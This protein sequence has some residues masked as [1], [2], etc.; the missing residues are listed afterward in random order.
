MQTQITQLTQITQETQQI[1]KQI[2]VLI[3][4]HNLRLLTFIPTSLLLNKV[5]DL[6]S[7]LSFLN[8]SFDSL[9][10]RFLVP[11]SQVV[12]L[13]A[14][15]SSS[16]DQLKTTKLVIKYLALF[17]Q[18]DSNNLLHSASTINLLSSINLPK[19]I[20]VID[21]LQSQ[22]D[23]IT[24][25]T[26]N[27][28]LVLLNSDM[29]L[30]LSILFNLNSLHTH[31]ISIIDGSL[32]NL[33]T[34]LGK[35]LS[36][37]SFWPE[38]ES[39]VDDIFDKSIYIFKLDYAIKSRKD[40]NDLITKSAKDGI[41]TYFYTCLALTIEKE[42]KDS[43]KSS[44]TLANL[45]SS[46]YPRLLRLFRDLFSRITL[47][48][49]SQTAHT[50]L[51]SS[52]SIF[53]H[54]HISK[55][56][57]KL[58]EPINSAFSERNSKGPIKEDIDKILRIISS[59]LDQVRFDQNLL[60]II[61]KNV[62]KALTTFSAKVENAIVIDLGIFCVGIN[63]NL[64]TNIDLANNLDRISIGIWKIINEYPN[65]SDLLYKNLT[66]LNELTSSLIQPIF[67]QIIKEFESTI[68]KIH[69][70]DFAKQKLNSPGKINENQTSSC[71]IE[72]S[73]RKIPWVI[74]EIL[75][76]LGSSDVKQWTLLLANR[77]I[78][79]YLRHVSIIFPL[80]D[81]G[82]LKIA[83]DL[84]CLFNLDAIGIKF[85]AITCFSIDKIRSRRIVIE[86]IQ[87]IEVF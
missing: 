54:S 76:K 86:N 58:L 62:D 48:D 52:L 24:T 74:Q 31:I 81:Y 11:Y 85:I 73:R 56:L 6:K 65:D 12:A 5:S 67:N 41:V 27:K 69:K 36:L 2:Q 55:S 61:N 75:L 4:K 87:A 77:I 80:N 14:D 47:H 78:I 66:V 30:G 19:G 28:A 46:N 39:F 26:T 68:I 44:K 37:S 32:S 3:Q 25:T 70:E 50:I 84:V 57:S 49:P 53:E 13:Q 64:I 59:E 7:S 29:P 18:L 9:K 43:A 72:F 20:H 83:S 35:A 60:K 40:F 38:M 51:L 34:A 33:L 1:Q 8:S 10:S 45:L 42:L 82:K 15:L 63:Q 22:L 16:L 79:F 21:N 23:T 71:I 17:N